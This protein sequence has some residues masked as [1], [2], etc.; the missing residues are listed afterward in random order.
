MRNII[1]AEALSTGYNFI[2]DIVCR[3]YRAVVLE[4]KA[5]GIMA[6]DREET[7]KKIK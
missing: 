4:C 7:Y 5:T 3:G 1:V 2:E 6:V